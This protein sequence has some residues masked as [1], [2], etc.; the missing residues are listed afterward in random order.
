MY[1]SLIFTDPD[2]NRVCWKERRR[3]DQAKRKWTL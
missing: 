1:N 3:G 2:Y